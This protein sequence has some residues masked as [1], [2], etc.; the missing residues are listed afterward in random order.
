MKTL[1]TSH[2]A[3]PSNKCQD[4]VI[5]KIN[6]FKKKYLKGCDRMRKKKFIDPRKNLFEGQTAIL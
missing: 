5:S 1:I 4:G 3:F 6:Y 2:C